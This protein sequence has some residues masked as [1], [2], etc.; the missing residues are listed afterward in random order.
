MQGT[1]VAKFQEMK[2]LPEDTYN[3]F[4]NALIK[5]ALPMMLY[6]LLKLTMCQWKE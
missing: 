6:T 2:R 1:L 3:L 4:K 5:W